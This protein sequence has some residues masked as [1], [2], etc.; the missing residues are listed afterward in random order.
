MY[1]L[2]L[3]ILY[4]I[5]NGREFARHG[6]QSQQRPCINGFNTSIKANIKKYHM[7]CSSTDIYIL[8]IIFPSRH[9][10]GRCL[11]HLSG[12]ESNLKK[13]PNFLFLGHKS[14]KIKFLL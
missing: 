12:L 3:M 8:T 7:P 9:F 6:H 14:P 10:Y 13:K 1:P 4:I 2:H 11:F 5:S